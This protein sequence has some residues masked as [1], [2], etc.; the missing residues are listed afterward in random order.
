LENYLKSVKFVLAEIG[1]GILEEL[2]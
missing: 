2:G 1:Y